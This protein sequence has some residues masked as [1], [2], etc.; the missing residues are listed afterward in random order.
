MVKNVNLGEKQC[1]A[2]GMVKTGPFLFVEF[3]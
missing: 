2:V 1:P 3:M